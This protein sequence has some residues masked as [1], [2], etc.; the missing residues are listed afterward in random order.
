MTSS[1]CATGRMTS[2]TPRRCANNGKRTA[3]VGARELTRVTK[4]LWRRK[5]KRELSTDYADYTENTRPRKCTKG[6]RRLAEPAITSD[7]LLCFL[8]LFVADWFFCLI[9]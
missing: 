7:F 9:C 3:G 2:S 5:L 8:C 6:T 1:I 4:T